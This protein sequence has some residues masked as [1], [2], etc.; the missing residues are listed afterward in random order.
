MR[1]R[2]YSRSDFGVSVLEEVT[3]DVFSLQTF[4]SFSFNSK[5][6]AP[7]SFS[8]INLLNPFNNL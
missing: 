6:L 5:H 2:V 1:P 3:F 4:I 7:K 8:H